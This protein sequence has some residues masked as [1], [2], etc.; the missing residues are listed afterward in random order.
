MAAFAKSGSMIIL[1]SYD[2]KGNVVATKGSDLKVE[3]LKLGGK[4]L[5]IAYGKPK[6]K[7]ICQFV[8][9][10]VNEPGVKKIITH[11]I[12]NYGV[13]LGEK[14][15]RNESFIDTTVTCTPEQPSAET[16]MQVQAPGE[17][18]LILIGCSYKD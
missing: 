13:F 14:K 15:D 17:G 9:D 1:G 8:V 12:C 5:T 11:A 2:A 6:P 4:A 3:K 18:K 10:E 16:T 7:L